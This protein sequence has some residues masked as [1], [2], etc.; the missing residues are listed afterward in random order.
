MQSEDSFVSLRSQRTMTRRLDL[1][2][3][4]KRDGGLLA[5]CTHFVRTQDF[6][7]IVNF[8]DNIESVSC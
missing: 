2:G 7:D 5:F 3:S 8:L 4:L 1:S 6:L